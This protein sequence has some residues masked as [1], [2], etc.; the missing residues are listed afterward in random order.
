MSFR[1]SAHAPQWRARASDGKP[2]ELISRLKQLTDAEGPTVILDS[3]RFN[4]SIQE[5]QI[6][7][8]FGSN[9]GQEVR[10]ILKDS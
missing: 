5:T 2:H 6:T 8:H 3:Y 1:I 4:P 7:L 10:T 9:K